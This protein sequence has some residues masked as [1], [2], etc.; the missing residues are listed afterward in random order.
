VAVLSHTTSYCSQAPSGGASYIRV[1]APTY[2]C[3]NRVASSSSAYIL[4]ATYIPRRI[5]ANS[6]AAHF[7]KLSYARFTSHP[8]RTSQI[9]GYR[10]RD[11]DRLR[12]CI[13]LRSDYNIPPVT[14]NRLQRGSAHT[15]SAREN[16]S[17]TMRTSSIAPVLG[18]R[19]RP[20]Y[21]ARPFIFTVFAICAL[22]L[23]AWASR[24]ARQAWKPTESLARRAVMQEDAE[25]WNVI[26]NRIVCS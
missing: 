24:G 10:N 21:S 15:S 22:S 4:I 18:L 6:T 23:V 12:D 8:Q 3:D 26:C 7:H 1:A 5:S 2:S 17:A 14:T 9:A 13:A 19:K 25:V 20:K 11:P 16:E